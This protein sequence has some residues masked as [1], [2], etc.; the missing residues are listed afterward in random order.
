MNAQWPPKRLAGALGAAFAS[1]LLLG[2]LEAED[3][4]TLNAEL[5]E[6]GRASYAM[7]CQACH[8]PEDPTIDSPSN[9]FD[10][11]WH[12]GDGSVENIEK[13]IRDGIVEKGMPAWGQMI[14]DEE[15]NALLQYLNS[16]QTKETAS[17]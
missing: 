9:L 4:P 2:V 7:F 5:V 16:F 11:K 6:K 15:I 12:H 8:G 14:S 13:S 1:S 10:L 3:S 17:K